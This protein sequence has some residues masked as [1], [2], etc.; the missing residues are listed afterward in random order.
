MNYYK[1]LTE[2]F[3]EAEFVNISDLFV[4]ARSVKTPE[5]IQMFRDLCRAADHGFT[6][7]SKIARVGV[8]EKELVQCFREDVIKSGFCAPSSWSM[9]STGTSGSV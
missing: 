9:F 2:K 1:M 6:E 3:P 4:Y 7:V 8:T 5:E